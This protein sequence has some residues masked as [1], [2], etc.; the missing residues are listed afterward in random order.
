[1]GSI[2][3]ANGSGA[4]CVTGAQQLSINSYTLLLRVVDG[5]VSW[6]TFTNHMSSFGVPLGSHADS[7][8][9]FA[10]Y[11][12]SS[13]SAPGLYK[14]ASLSFT[15]TSGAPY[16][17]IAPFSPT[18]QSWMTAFGSDC[19]GFEADNTMRFGAEWHDAHG[20][21]EYN[22]WPA[23]GVAIASGNLDEYYPS[24]V[25]DGAGAGIIAWQQAPGCWRLLL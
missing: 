12:G 4:S 7:A 25:S 22:P 14:L 5:T 9:Y 8:S 20:L 1:M 6:G 2:P 24:V 23:N 21:D 10:G 15:I 13:Y 3:N 11:G 18:D 16:V 19:L 17:L